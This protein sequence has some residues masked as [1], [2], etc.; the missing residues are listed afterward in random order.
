VSAPFVSVVI[1]AYNQAQW[2]TETVSSA[3]GQD[4]DPLEVVVAD[5]GS[6]DDTPAMLRD[7]AERHAGRLVPILGEKNLGIAGNINRALSRCQGELIA[8]QGGDDVL[9]PGKIARQVGFMQDHP[10]CGLCYHDVDVF[11]SQTDETLYLWSQR[12]GRRRG[13]AWDMVRFG[14]FACATAVMARRRDIPAGG[15]DERIRV[16]CDWLLFV[17]ILV[18]AGGRAGY[19]DEV[20]ARYRR[21]EQNVTSTWEWKLE[22]QLLTLAVI[23]AHWPHLLGASRRRRSDLLATAA[24]RAFAAGQPRDGWRFFGEAWLQA[25]PNPVAW[26]RLVWRELRFLA[27]RGGHPDDVTRG[28]FSP[29]QPERKPPSQERVN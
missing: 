7:L 1:P 25:F 23:E 18:S 10:D 5:D 29:N 17:E 13:S 28:L 22:D 27:R 8:L 6:Q 3:L 2:I 24:V 15:C 16:G 20:L 9:L 26:T 11:D 12:Y 4:Y 14:P 19:V 21:H